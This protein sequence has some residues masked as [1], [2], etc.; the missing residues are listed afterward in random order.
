MDD[1]TLHQA[2][3]E[4]LEW[5]PHVDAPDVTVSVRDGIVSLRGFV[6]N[7]AEKSTAERAVWHVRGMRGL[8]REMEVLIPEARRHSDD[9]IVH[10]VWS[11]PGWDTQV[12]GDRVRV[13]VELGVVSLIASVD[14]QFQN[15]E[16]EDRTCKLAGVT[17]VDDRIL[18]QPENVTWSTAGVA[19]VED[20]L[21]VQP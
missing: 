20:Q 17:R 6:A 19:E 10:R 11:A 5:A 13:K 14:W 15:S 2:V 8:A 9:G 4:E 16:P 1:V 18:V 12:R 7:L 21:A 3:A